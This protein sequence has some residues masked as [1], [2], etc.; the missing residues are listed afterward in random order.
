MCGGVGAEKLTITKGGGAGPQGKQEPGLALGKG[1]E[2]TQELTGAGNWTERSQ[3]VVEAI[4]KQLGTPGA[5][6]ASA[7]GQARS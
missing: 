2:S 4:E 1:K 6:L 3:G 7:W 5:C